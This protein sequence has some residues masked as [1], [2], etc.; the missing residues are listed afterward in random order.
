MRNLLLLSTSLCLLFSLSAWA[1]KPEH[2]AHGKDKAMKMEKKLDKQNHHE[3]ME[4]H[5]EL[6]DNMA[7]HKKDKMKKM[8]KGEHGDMKDEHHADMDDAKQGMEKQRDKK[9]DQARNELGK[10]SEQGQQQRAANSKK[11][12]KFWGE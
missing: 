2:A 9:A 6:D 7:K 4:G 5:E 11:W 8:H 10:G 1:D 12:W 3:A